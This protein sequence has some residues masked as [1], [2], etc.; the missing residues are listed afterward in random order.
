MS[1]VKRPLVIAG[2]RGLHHARWL[3]VVAPARA[4]IAGGSPDATP[5]V[6]A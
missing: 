6:A 3:V 4:A 5:T 2:Y 1:A